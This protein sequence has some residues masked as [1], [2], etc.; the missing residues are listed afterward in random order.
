MTKKLTKYA[1]RR[2]RGRRRKSSRKNNHDEKAEETC[3]T[4]WGLLGR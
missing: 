2:K 1:K 4:M 3:G